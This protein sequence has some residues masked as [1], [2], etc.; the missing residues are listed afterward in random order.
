MPHVISFFPLVRGIMGK[1]KKKKKLLLL[2]TYLV[3]WNF[4]IKKIAS[5][6]MAMVN[7]HPQW[8]LHLF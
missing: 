8:D 3:S 7:Q 6:F 2:D 1:K 4:S 5:I